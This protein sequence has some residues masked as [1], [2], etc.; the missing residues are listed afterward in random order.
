MV[1]VTVSTKKINPKQPIAMENPVSFL[2]D[3]I[4]DLG[5]LSASYVSWNWL[6]NKWAFPPQVIF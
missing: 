3:T 4:Q 5:W 1:H 6:A 2:V